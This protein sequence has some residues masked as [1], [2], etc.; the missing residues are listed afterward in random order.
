MKS[1]SIV[2]RSDSGQ[3][4]CHHLLPQNKARSWTDVAAAFFA[5]KDETTGAHFDKRLQEQG[6]WH[7]QISGDA[8]IFKR[9]GLVGAAAGDQGE[10]RAIFEDY[11]KLFLAQLLAHKSEN[12]DTPGE[13]AQFFFGFGT[14]FLRFIFAHQSQSKK[15]QAASG[16]HTVS[17]I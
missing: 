17:K 14:K 8:Q 12:A 13:A 3:E 16:R 9:F 6:R 2:S 4:F 11:L 5:F 15:R 7:V 10:G 1:G